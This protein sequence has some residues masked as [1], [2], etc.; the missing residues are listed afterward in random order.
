MTTKPYVIRVRH[1]F[2]DDT[3]VIEQSYIEA[4]DRQEVKYWYHNHYKNWGH[5]PAWADSKHVIELYDQVV[6][7]EHIEYIQDPFESGVLSEW[8]PHFPKDR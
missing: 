8:M 2:G 5:H 6:D 1:D 4:E 3:A 7:L